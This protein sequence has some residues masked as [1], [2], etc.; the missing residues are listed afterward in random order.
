[1]G[2]TAVSGADGLG[3][4][5]LAP[6]PLDVGLVVSAHRHGSGDPAWRVDAAD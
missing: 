4:D 1:M 3:R 2:L 5:W 6:F